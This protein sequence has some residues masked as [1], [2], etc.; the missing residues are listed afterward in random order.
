MSDLVLGDRRRQVVL[1]QV[2]RR[3]LALRRR[4]R[5]H[6][7][8]ALGGQQDRRH[9]GGRVAVGE[10]AADRPAVAHLLVG[11]RR[12]G[13]RGQPEVARSP[14]WWCVVIAPIRTVPLSR[15][16]PVQPGDPAQVDQQRR[17]RQPQLH[18][19]QQRVAAGEQLRV[20][21]ALAQRAERLVER[22]G[23]R[24]SRTRRGSCRTS[25]AGAVGPEP[26][27][28]LPW[29]SSSLPCSVRAGP[30]PDPWASWIACHT[31]IGVSGM[32]M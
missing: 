14:T 20:L 17:R 21:A 13:R 25:L 6:G 15:S 27:A 22:L 30:S 19:R 2:G 11:D 1:E 18:Q 7:H 12:R 26:A 28:P 32:S 10:R 24:R 9:V 29:S 4:R 3:D 8:R 5:G 23:R 31:R 16:M